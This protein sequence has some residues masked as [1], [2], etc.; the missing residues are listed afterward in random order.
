MT[1][2]GFGF[3]TSYDSQ[4]DKQQASFILSIQDS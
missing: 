3:K 4:F 1:S 2:I